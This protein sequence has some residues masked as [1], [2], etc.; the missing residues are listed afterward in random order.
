[1]LLLAAHVIAAMENPADISVISSRNTGQG[2]VLTFAAATGFFPPGTF[3]NQIQAAFREP[4]LLEVTN[5]RASHQSLLE[6]SCIRLP[7]IAPCN[8]DSPLRY[9]DIAISCNNKGAWDMMMLTWE[10]L[11]MLCA[12]SCEHPQEVMPDRCFLGDLEEVKKEEQAAAEKA[13]TK[14]EFQGKWTAPASEFTAIQPEVADWS[15]G[16]QMPPAPVQQFQLRREPS[17]CR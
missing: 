14:E 15:E 12:I 11:S 3:A 8:T 4:R 17:A 13:V 10:V 7:A 16:M 6:A 9:V 2:A 1:M 5:P